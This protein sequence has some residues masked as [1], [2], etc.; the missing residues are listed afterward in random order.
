MVCFSRVPSWKREG[1]ELF[2]CM[3]WDT[4]SL[5]RGVQGMQEDTGR[6]PQ[7]GKSAARD[8]T[9]GTLAETN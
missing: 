9:K 4:Y 8:Q 1:P 5:Q 6:S 2:L 7:R 3:S